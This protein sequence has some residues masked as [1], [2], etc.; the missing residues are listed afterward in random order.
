MTVARSEL[1]APLRQAGFRRLATGRLLMYFA[2]AMAPS[3]WRS[4]CST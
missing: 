3:Y 2:N 1:V 4:P